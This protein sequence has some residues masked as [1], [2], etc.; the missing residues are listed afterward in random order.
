[1]VLMLNKIKEERGP[2]LANDELFLWNI[3]FQLWLYFYQ[4]IIFQLLVAVFL[5][6][7]IRNLVKSIKLEKTS[8][9]FFVGKDI[10]LFTYYNFLFSLQ[11]FSLW[12]ELSKTDWP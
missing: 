5:K 6:Q 11:I 9:Y 7:H 10:N 8:L 3:H 12:N 1:M 4:N 2:H